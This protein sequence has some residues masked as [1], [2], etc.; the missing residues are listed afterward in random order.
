MIDGRELLKLGNTIGTLCG[1]EST[2][3]AASIAGSWLSILWLLGRAGWLL[4][5]ELVVQISLP[6]S[7]LLC[8]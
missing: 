1:F 7:L 4:T 2:W 8:P 5:K 6:P 3:G